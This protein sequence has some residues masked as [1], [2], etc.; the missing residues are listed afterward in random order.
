MPWR[1]NPRRNRA[2][3]VESSPE[4]SVRRT[5]SIVRSV[6]LLMAIGFASRGARAQDVTNDGRVGIVL[7]HPTIVDSLSGEPYFWFDDQTGDVTQFRVAFP[8][9]IYH[10]TPWLQGWGGVFVNWK[11]QAS[12]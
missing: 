4:L 2:F 10:A 8:N 5:S 3:A 12:G 6:F 9:L 1:F 7:A 11:N